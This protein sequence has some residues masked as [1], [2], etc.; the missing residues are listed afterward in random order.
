[1]TYGDRKSPRIRF[2]KGVAALLMGID[3]TWRR[4]CTLA[5]ISASGARLI[6]LEPVAGLN[7]QEFF[8]VLTPSGSIFRRCKLIRVNGNEIG[9]G[10]VTPAK[11][12]G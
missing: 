1:V 2:E 10:F 6:L 7:I 8:L 4:E 11:S 12:R 9:V 5:D 3:G